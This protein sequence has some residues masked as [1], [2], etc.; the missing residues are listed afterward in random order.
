MT[1]EKAPFNSAL[2]KL[3]SLSLILKDI[4][5]LE[6]DPRISN[7]VK[8]EH[9]VRLVIQYYVNANPLLSTEAREKFKVILDLEPSSVKHI[10]TN[11]SRTKDNGYLVKYNKE[12]DK[13]LNGYLIELQND[14]QDKGKYFMPPRRDKGKAV[15][16]F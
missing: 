12:L 16:Q 3:E 4:V 14:L 6:S 13:L 2:D 8:Q 15:G 7:A 5:R 11:G 1:D 9:K 10:I